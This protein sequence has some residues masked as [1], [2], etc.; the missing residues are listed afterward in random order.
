MCVGWVK[1]GW[2]IKLCDSRH[3]PHQNHRATLALRQPA[4]QFTWDKS[5]LPGFIYP[6]YIATPVAGGVAVVKLTLT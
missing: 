4:E 1:A 3:H 5:H 6:S 2:R